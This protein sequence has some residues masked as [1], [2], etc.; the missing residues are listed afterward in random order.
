MLFV[1]NVLISGQAHPFSHWGELLFRTAYFLLFAFPRP[2]RL[3]ENGV[4]Y[5]QVP[6]SVRSGFVA[7]DRLERYRFEGDILILTGT[8]S[9]LKGGS[10]RGGVFH[11]RPDRRPNS[12][13]RSFGVAG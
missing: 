2:L 3:Y 10:V 9:T 8:D 1:G 12:T 6:D 4:R 7:W 5:T 11:L 13:A